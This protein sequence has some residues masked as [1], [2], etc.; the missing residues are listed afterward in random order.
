MIMTGEGGGEEKQNILHIPSSAVDIR[1]AVVRRV[2]IALAC[3]LTTRLKKGRKS[4]FFILKYSASLQV[5]LVI[6]CFRLH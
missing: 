5:N 6:Y 3:Y 2:F 1:A 4:K